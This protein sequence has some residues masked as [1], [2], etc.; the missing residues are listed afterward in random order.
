MLSKTRREKRLPEVPIIK[1]GRV[2]AISLNDLKM[3]ILF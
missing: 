1:V 2:E 3:K